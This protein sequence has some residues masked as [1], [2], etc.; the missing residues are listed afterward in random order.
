MAQQGEAPMTD[1]IVPNPGFEQYSSTPIGWFYKGD[2]FTQVMKYWNA[3]T[4]ASPDVFGPK[5]R[6]PS[7]WK[8]KGFGQQQ[9]HSGKNMVGI[10]VY[11]CENGKPHCREYIQ[12]QLREPLVIGQN[13]AAEFWVSQL[14]LSLQINQLG[15]YL[16]TD[17][18]RKADDSQLEFFPQIKSENIIQSPGNSWTKISGRF[19]AT[20]EAEYLTIGN[21]FSDSLTQSR[22]SFSNHLNYAY[23]YIDDV[24]VKKEEP[25]LNVPIREDDLSRISVEEGKLITLKNI[26]FD[27]DKVEL[28]P[29]SFSE[30]N[31]LV[32]LMR[33]HPSMIIKIIGHTD[34]VGEAAYNLELSERRAR[35]VINYLY[36]KGIP[37]HRALHAGYGSSQPIA[38]NEDANGRQLN[39][40]VELL[41]LKK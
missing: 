27:H 5:V 3:P 10:T 9:A 18:I 38:S 14:P 17:P 22:S 2:H 12:I 20:T 16:S 41:I 6:V 37:A 30:L 39:R 11:G 36:K 1:N 8:E 7:Y 26:F 15:I 24:S 4:A 28:L 33:I 40:R 31:K 19:T 13:Y 35:A 25:I 29:R 21:F 34:S 32:E 23:Y